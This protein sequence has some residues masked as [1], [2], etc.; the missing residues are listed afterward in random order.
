MRDAHPAPAAAGNGLDHDRVADLLGDGEGFLLALNHAL[1]AGREGDAGLLGKGAGNLLVLQRVH[2]AGAGAD[3]A[4]VAALA[5][6]RE[7]GVL[8]EEAVAG[9]DGV[10][11][12][13]SAARSTGRYLVTVC[14]GLLPC[15]WL[16]RPV[17]RGWSW[18]RRGIHHDRPDVEVFARPDYPDRDLTSVGD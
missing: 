10:H 14:A 5:D 4:D 13:D 17:G 11:I 2:G 15:K 3:E 8:R 1:G 12:G 6:V 9:M 16:R 7:V 18:R